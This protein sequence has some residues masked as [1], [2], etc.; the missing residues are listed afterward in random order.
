MYMDMYMYSYIHIS[1]GYAS[2]A[3]PLNPGGPE[4]EHSFSFFTLLS[5]CGGLG[6]FPFARGLGTFP[7][8]F[9]FFTLLSPCGGLGT[10]PFRR[11]LGTFPIQFKKRTRRRR[12]EEAEEE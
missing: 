12:K 7:I 6:T 9:S 3:G 10:F 4:E 11:G 5:P 1:E 8:Q 2:A